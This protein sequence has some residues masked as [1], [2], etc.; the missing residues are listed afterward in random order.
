MQNAHNANLFIV[1]A[2]RTVGDV[3][4]NKQMLLPGFFDF[5][6]QIF[7]HLVIVHFLAEIL[8]KKKI[9]LWGGE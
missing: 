6:T 2:N 8:R 9:F 7:K 1:F 4:K 5:Y 3:V